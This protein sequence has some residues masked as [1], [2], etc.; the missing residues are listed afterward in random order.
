MPTNSM[1]VMDASLVQGDACRPHRR[2]DL[3]GL[4]AGKRYSPKKRQRRNAAI[5]NDHKVGAGSHAPDDRAEAAIFPLSPSAPSNERSSSLIQPAHPEIYNS[6]FS[7]DK[8]C[9]E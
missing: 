9:K 1:L 4:F 7:A 2:L 3:E 5:W 6:R 8:A